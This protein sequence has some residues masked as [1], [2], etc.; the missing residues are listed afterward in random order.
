MSITLANKNQFR[1]FG[2]LENDRLESQNQCLAKISGWYATDIVTLEDD[3]DLV[4][5]YGDTNGLFCF[6]VEDIT[7]TQ[8]KINYLEWWQTDADTPRYHDGAIGASSGLQPMIRTLVYD[9]DE[10]KVV[11]LYFQKLK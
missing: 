8:L 7:G 6:A 1:S 4:A 5:T 11:K 9:A 3:I 10:C 2:T